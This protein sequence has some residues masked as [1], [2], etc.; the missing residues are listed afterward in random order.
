[1]NH[2][3]PLNF[4]HAEIHFNLSEKNAAPNQ[5]SPLIIRQKKF[6][7]FILSLTKQACF[8]RVSITTEANSELLNENLS[9]IA[10]AKMCASKDA[11]I[12]LITVVR[13]FDTIEKFSGANVIG[14]F[15]GCG[16]LGG[17]R[18]WSGRSSWAELN[19]TWGE[20]NYW[21]F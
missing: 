2:F 1:M 17:C 21:S 12:I 14:R 11:L 13:V 18:G 20:E 16:G 7:D 4:N 9:W 19:E 15:S 8:A 3:R 5:T 6:H 10:R